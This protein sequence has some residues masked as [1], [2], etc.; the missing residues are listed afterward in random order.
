MHIRYLKQHEI[1]HNKWDNCIAHSF[2][3]LVYGYSWYLDA[4]CQEWHALVEEDYERVWPLIVKR[5]YGID[6]LYQPFFTQQLGLFSRKILNSE[7]L[8][9]FIKAIPR[10]FK[11]AEI[12]LN[13]LNKIESEKY[14]VIPQ[15]NLEL[16]LI[17]PYEKIKNKYSKNLKRNL[18]KAGTQ[19]LGINRSIK[20]DE[21]IRL[22]R[23]N[24]GK[25]LKHLKEADYLRFKRLVYTAIYKGMADVYGVYSA[26][27]EIC[28]AAI[29][30][31]SHNRASFVFSGLSEY[32]KELGAMSYLIDTYI[33]D[34]AERH[35]TFDFE[36]SNDEGLA[37]FYKS[38]G[39][40]EVWYP[41]LIINRL[42]SLQALFFNY[43][44]SLKK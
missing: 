12:S 2:N 10:K 27:N 1:D 43:H 21:A 19:N 14:H 23:E 8:E 4:V 32:G 6:L 18:K 37:H 31:R 11:Y 3:G 9:K 15:L 44:R 13:A 33:Q 20:P 36:G 34:H 25:N 24:R 7:L 26:M 17:N 30:I 5:K 22:F 29:F 16:D 35:L 41:K 38:F 39:A 40:Q 42:N 28:A